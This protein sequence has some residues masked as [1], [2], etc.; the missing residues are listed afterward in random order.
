MHR[1]EAGERH[2]EVEAHRH[3]ALAV[4]LEAVD[5]AVVLAA[6]LA[7]QNVGVFQR[8]RVDGGVAVTAVDGA[9]RL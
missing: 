8:R 3:V 6:A 2:G 1:G 4:I 5:D 9:R 7:Q